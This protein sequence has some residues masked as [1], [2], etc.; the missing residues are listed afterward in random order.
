VELEAFAN[1]K[2]K[3]SQDK[4]NAEVLRT[5]NNNQKSNSKMPRNKAKRAMKQN[6]VKMKHIWSSKPRKKLHLHH[7]LRS[8]KVKMKLLICKLS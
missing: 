5:K 6:K 7:Y 8:R 3:C 4:E 2:D 1:I